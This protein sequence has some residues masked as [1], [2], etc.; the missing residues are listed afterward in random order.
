MTCFSS[1]QVALVQLAR[2]SRPTGTRVHAAQAAGAADGAGPAGKAGAGGITGTS[3][4]LRRLSMPQAKQILMGLGV[5]ESEINGARPLLPPALCCPLH[6]PG[7]AAWR[8][9]CG[10]QAEPK[11]L[12]LHRALRSWPA[13]LK[14]CSRQVH[15]IHQTI[16]PVCPVLPAH[17]AFTGKMHAPRLHEL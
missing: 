3:S 2:A 6:A 15:G 8:A 4:D 7:P 12:Q 10:W 9:A 13:S 5:A 16:E 1:L 11:R 17:C 14:A